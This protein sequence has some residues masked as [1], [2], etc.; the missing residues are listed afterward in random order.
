MER[1]RPRRDPRQR[2]RPARPGGARR[3][4]RGREGE[5]LRPRRG[6]GGA[7]RAGRRRDLVGR[8][9]GRRGGAAARRRRRRPGDAAVGA[10]AA[11]RRSGRRAAADAGRLHRAGDR[12]A[13]RRPSPTPDAPSRST[14]TSRSTPACTAWAALPKKRSTLA[15]HVAARTSS[16][17]L[18][19][20]RTSPSPTSPGTRTPPTSSAGS[21]RC[22]TTS[23]ARDLRPPLV[24]A[25]N[26]AALLDRP[27][28]R[29]T[30][31]CG[32][33]SRCYGLPPAPGA[34]RRGRDL[35]P[36][37]ALAAGPRITTVK[38][39]AGRCAAVVRVAVGGRAV[40]EGG[41]GARRLRRRR[42]AQPRTRRRRGPDRG[43]R[44]PIVGVRDDGPADGRRSAT[45]RLT[46]TTRSCSSA[47]RATTRSPPPSGR[48]RLDTIAY[49]IVTGIG[50]RGRAHR[51]AV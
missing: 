48:T 25:A 9:P 46:S 1:G 26:S 31:S 47:A 28:A 10:G 6:A 27:E 33:A 24:H 42:A 19:C 18:A 29:A 14:C 44:R 49:E 8:G 50:A 45:A 37:G 34:R 4:A 30:T 13:R 51:W 32:S 38:T 12:R 43:R 7:G 40:G 22:S 39:L 20:A 17:S 41:D 5:R 16:R 15:T 21:T 23:A 11:G 36:A 2:P 35:A 3:A